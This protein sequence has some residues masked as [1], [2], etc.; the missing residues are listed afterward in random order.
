[1]SE[2]DELRQLIDSAFSPWVPSPSELAKQLAAGAVGAEQQLFAAFMLAVAEHRLEA[3]KAAHQE[4]MSIA[5][6][7]EENAR[8]AAAAILA[9][10]EYGLAAQEQAAERLKGILTADA[11]AE[12]GGDQP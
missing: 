3:A 11:D 7:S 8:R 10:A 12:A 4:F 2:Q 5:G 9:A 1:M 6:Q